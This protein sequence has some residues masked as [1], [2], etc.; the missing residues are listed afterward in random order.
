MFIREIFSSSWGFY[1][2]N[3]SLAMKIDDDFGDSY[4]RCGDSKKVNI[5]FVEKNFHGLVLIRKFI[6]IALHCL[7]IIDEIKGVG[8]NRY[9]LPGDAQ[10]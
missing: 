8:R 2:L 5:C 7:Q 3:L 4:S 6:P 1:C 9:N 10:R